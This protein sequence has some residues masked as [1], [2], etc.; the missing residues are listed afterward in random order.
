MNCQWEKY[1]DKYK[2][3]YCG[4]IVPDNTFVK[5]CKANEKE[6][7]NIVKRGA[8][9]SRALFEHTKTGLKHCT[10]EEKMVRFEICQ[11]NKC[12]LFR[13]HG[14]VGICAHDSCGCFIRNSG[15]FMDKLSWAESKCPV[16]LWGPTEKIQENTQN[17]V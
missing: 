17:G 15:K 1:D 4:F 11:S 3:K 5:N 9:F 12:G 2:C 16:G 13:K 14:N 10:N 7:P 6:I 8:N